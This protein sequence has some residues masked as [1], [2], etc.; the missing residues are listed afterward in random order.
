MSPYWAGTTNVYQTDPNHTYV[1][2]VWTE[3]V[4]D[5]PY[6]FNNAGTVGTSGGD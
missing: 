4:G 6:T 5:I 3:T 1:D 2:K